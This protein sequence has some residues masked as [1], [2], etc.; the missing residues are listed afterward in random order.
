MTG[1]DSH[2]H[3]ILL[4]D[5]ECLFCHAS[6]R[7][8]VDRDAAGYFRFGAAQDER[9]QPLLQRYGLADITASTIV[10]IEQDQVHLRSTAALRIARHLGWPWKAMAVFLI[11][12]RPLRD[13]VYDLVA[14]VR[15]RL[16]GRT[17][18]CE[19]PSEAIRQRLI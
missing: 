19:L 13:A 9:A 15:H 7:F 17:D 1:M 3:G 2:T 4:Y 18:V 5:G 12:P 14:S 6:M 8:I 11:V 10:L 16:F